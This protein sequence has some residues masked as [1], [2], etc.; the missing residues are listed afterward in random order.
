M[1]KLLEATMVDSIFEQ[2]NVPTFVGYYYK[3]E[4]QQDD[5]VSAIA[6][7]EMFKKLGSPIK[8]IKQLEEV[9]AHAMASSL[10]SKDIDAVKEA[11]FLFAVTKLHL[12]PLTHSN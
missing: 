1:Q 3:N 11:S 7:Q 6:T 2:I 8:E 5:V 9:G 12:M 10:F 4:E